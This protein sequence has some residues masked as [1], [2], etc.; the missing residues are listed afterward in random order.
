MSFP[1][2]RDQVS[3]P[4]RTTG[5]IIVLYILIFKFFD[6]RW[7][8][9]RFWTETEFNLLLISSWIKFWF[10]TVAP[11]YLN[12]DT[13]SNDLFATFMSRFWPT[14]WWRDS[15]IY[16]VSNFKCAF[17]MTDLTFTISCNCHFTVEPPCLSFGSIEEKLKWKK[18]YSGIIYLE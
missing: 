10:V 4:Y 13:F 5:K 12:C 18:F 17:S 11:K 1:Y 9:R 8:D 7:E 15:S 14:F 3:H 6:S 2:F 16:L